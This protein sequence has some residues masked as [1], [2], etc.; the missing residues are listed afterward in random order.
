MIKFYV[1]NC[2]KVNIYNATIVVQVHT[3]LKFVSGKKRENLNLRKEKISVHK[4]TS[5]EMQLY[6][7]RN[8]S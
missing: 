5:L 3:L 1:Y 8:T 6:F 2:K 7:C 4:E